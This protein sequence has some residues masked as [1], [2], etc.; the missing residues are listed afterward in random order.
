MP[1]RA[2]VDLG[3]DATNEL[4]VLGAS[5]ETINQLLREISA[6]VSTLTD[7]ERRE[8]ARVAL[9]LRKKSCGKKIAP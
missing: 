5:M 2:P 3:D 6:Y 9:K 8:R 1:L 4:Y 7:P